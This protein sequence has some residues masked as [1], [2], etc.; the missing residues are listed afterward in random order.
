MITKALILLI[1]DDPL[2]HE[3][4]SSTLSKHGHKVVSVN[5][6]EDAKRWLATGCPDLILMDIILPDINGLDLCRWVR[7]QGRF[8]N[9]PIIVSTALTDEGTS[10]ESSEVGAIDIITKPIN[11]ALLTKKIQSALEA[12]DLKNP[13]S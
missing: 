9:V 10:R 11:F 3:L 12:S 8:K 4:L 2:I 1:D 7:D 5:N 13:K 6:A